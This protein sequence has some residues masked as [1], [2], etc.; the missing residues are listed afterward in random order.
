MPGNKNIPQAGVIAVDTTASPHRVMLVTSFGRQRWVLP[1]GHIERGQTPR[2]AA[3]QEAY[4]EAGVRGP[5][6]KRRSGVYTYRKL[7]EPEKPP[8]TVKVYTMLVDEILKDW[9]EKGQRRR[10]WMDFTSAIA[11]VEEPE[12]RE[13]LSSVQMKLADDNP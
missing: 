6:Q 1:K 7:D 10:K 4:E 2:Q 12:L 5:L 9:P 3:C 11:V 13:I 8:F